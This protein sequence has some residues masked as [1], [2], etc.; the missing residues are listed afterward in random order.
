MKKILIK[1][2]ETNT[3]IL[4][5]NNR[6]FNINLFINNLHNCKI[7]TVIESST[8]HKSIMISL[9]KYQFYLQFLDLQS[10]LAGGFLDDN[11]KIFTG[12]RLKCV[13]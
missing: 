6:N 7:K 1:E 2:R 9:K 4:G 10:F 8:Q 12:E 5:F 3:R 13:F 11:V